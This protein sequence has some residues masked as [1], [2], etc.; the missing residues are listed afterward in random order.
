MPGMK[1]LALAVLL[2]L[3]LAPTAQAGDLAA[4]QRVLNREMA[5]SGALSGAYVVDVRTGQELYSYR[6]D[7]GRA[8]ASFDTLA[9]LLVTASTCA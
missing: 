2:V 6:A 1:Q 9:V 4:T 7:V 5:R 3:L 8:P